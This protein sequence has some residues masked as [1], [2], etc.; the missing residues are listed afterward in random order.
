MNS[1]VPKVYSPLRRVY[2]FTILVCSCGMILQAQNVCAQVT[3]Q[4]GIKYGISVSDLDWVYTDESNAYNSMDLGQQK[5]TGFFTT[6]TFEYF[7]KRYWNM[8]SGFGFY[9]KGGEIDEGLFYKWHL[10]YLTLDTQVKLKYPLGKFSPHLLFGPRI[11][12]LVKYSSDMDKY[13]V[14]ANSKIN[15]TNAGLRYGLGIDYD[16]GALLVNLGWSNNLNFNDI[17]TSSSTSNIYAATIKD[18]TMVFY[19]GVLVPVSSRSN[20]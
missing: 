15:K 18:K 10:D 20:K 6:V 1:A 7:N 12:Y 16:F 3:D 13:Q 4:I 17:L 19:I 2:Q 9:Q 5:L 11:D 8:S 14:K